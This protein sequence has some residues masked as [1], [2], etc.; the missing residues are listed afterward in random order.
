V[1]DRSSCIE[2]AEDGGWIGVVDGG[3][4]QRVAGQ[5]GH[6]RGFHPFAADVAEEE[7]PPVPGQREQVVEVAADLVRGGHVVVGGGLHAGRDDQ[8]ARQQAPL[9]GGDQQL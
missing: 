7:S 4:A 3:G 8:L 2:V 1:S 6:R 5:R 9:Q